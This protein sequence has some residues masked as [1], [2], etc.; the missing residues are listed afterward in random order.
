MNTLFIAEIISLSVHGYL[1]Q[2]FEGIPKARK[3]K[4][5]SI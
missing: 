5:Q 1:T 2:T 4:I 3:R